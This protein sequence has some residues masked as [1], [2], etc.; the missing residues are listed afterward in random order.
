MRNKQ[1]RKILSLPYADT[2]PDY[3]L[4]TVLEIRKH[5]PELTHL[6]AHKLATLWEEFSD[7]RCAGWLVHEGEMI[8]EFWEWCDEDV[9]DNQDEDGEEE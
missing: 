7:D 4:E 9:Y 8:Q 5:C 3:Q 2:L 1:W 6:A